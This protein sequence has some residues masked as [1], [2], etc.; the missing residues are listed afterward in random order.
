LRGFHDELALEYDPKLLGDIERNLP[1]LVI[2][3]FQH[4][5]GSDGTTPRT[6]GSRSDLH[7]ILDEVSKVIGGLIEKLGEEEL[8]KVI[9][10]LKVFKGLSWD[11]NT[12]AR[13]PPGLEGVKN[14]AFKY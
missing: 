4:V 14:A 2:H 11:A 8:K 3:I 1:R 13:R 12:G 10:I 9:S 5:P 7:G 6:N